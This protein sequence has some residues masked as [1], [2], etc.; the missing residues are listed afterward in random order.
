MGTVFSAIASLF[1]AQEMEIAVV[2]LQ[3]AGK[4]SLVSR[5]STGEFT[6]D[7]MPTIG[8]NMHK[9]KKG[10]T[11]LK[12]WDIAGQQK[13]RNLWGRYARGCSVIVFVVDLSTPNQFETVKHE[14]QD[15]MMQ[16]ALSDIPLLC[17]FNKNDMS[18]AVPL[19]QA[20]VAI[21][22]NDIR[23][24]SVSYFSISCQSGDNIEK[25]MQFLTSKAREKNKA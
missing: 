15:L 17:L 6:P 14:L 8:F 10:R 13:F 3:A 16:Q 22:L 2:G 23:N 7:L 9:I 20:I 21:G 5:F 25:V 19:D 4:S 24:R 18:T 11:V 12:V 1:W